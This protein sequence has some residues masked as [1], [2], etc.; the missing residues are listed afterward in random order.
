VILCRDIYRG[1]PGSKWAYYVNPKTANTSMVASLPFDEEEILRGKVQ[2]YKKQ[3]SK[4]RTQVG[5]PVS[6]QQEA[7]VLGED[8]FRFS[9]VRNPFDRLV[10]WWLNKICS[11]DPR[12]CKYRQVHGWTRGVSFET[13]L[14]S[15][16][17][18]VEITPLPEWHFAPQTRVLPIDRL[19]F[20]GRYEHI[21]RDWQIVMEKIP[22]TAALKRLN[23]S[24][25]RKPWQRYYRGI[26]DAVVA[27]L[28]MAFKDDFEVLNYPKEICDHG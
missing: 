17:K 2:S 12:C 11:P 14:K 24:G 13:A 27:G 8:I 18:A 5:M 19:T 22:G 20:V 3:G 10:S 26:S 15:V 23:V 6:E 16:I 4:R 28:V 21:D 7:L 9:F 25:N 1:K